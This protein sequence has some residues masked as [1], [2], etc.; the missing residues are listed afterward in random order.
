[1][2][3]SPAV[4]PLFSFGFGTLPRSSGSYSGAL[5][6][7]FN[8]V[9][10]HLLSISVHLARKTAV[11]FFV[12]SHDLNDFNVFEFSRAAA[13][14]DFWHHI[15]NHIYGDLSWGSQIKVIILAGEMLS[16]AQPLLEQNI[17]PTLIVSGYMAAL[18]DSLKLLE[19]IAIPINTKDEKEICILLMSSY[20]FVI[21]TCELRH[22]MQVDCCTMSDSVA[23]VAA[24][25]EMLSQCDAATHVSL[26]G[27]YK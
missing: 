20:Q 14:K 1:M 19:D 22:S 12:S 3:T 18:E 9:G 26:S 6:S 16:V 25:A 11:A 13:C 8:I 7:S 17:H 4:L 10:P 27:G 21:G 15:D 2:L 24:C 5:L 23:M